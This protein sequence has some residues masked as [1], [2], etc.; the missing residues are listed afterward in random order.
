[1]ADP[2][3]C[4]DLIAHRRYAYAKLA[5]EDGDWRAAA[6]VLE[7][8][9]ERAPEWA[10][11]LFALAE[12]REKLGDRDGAAEAFNAT[13]RAD[14]R[15][16]QGAAAR[17]AQIG[18]ADAPTALPRAYVT[19][20]FD[21][22]APRFNAHLTE[23]LA[24]R[25]PELIIGALDAVDDKRRFARALDLGCGAGLMGEAL[26]ARVE[27]LV[28]VDLSAAMIAKSREAAVYDALEVGD[29]VESLERRERG[30]FDLIVAADVLAYIG[31]LEPILGAVARALAPSGW[32]ACTVESEAGEGFRLGATMRFVH[33][34]DYV[35]ARA[36]AAGLRPLVCVD[37]WA[38]REAAREAPGLVLVFARG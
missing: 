3:A 29:V 38:R 24:Y 10:P 23:A 31:A 22:Y 19:R 5:A 8:A 6:E 12:A 9:L 15:D 20:L 7:Q 37:A 16:A 28:G 34:R 30:A 18:A 35:L 14:P 21:G 11:A 36:T 17:L 32:F 4:A 2:L 27:E 33:S 1:L 13:L 25:G 26:R